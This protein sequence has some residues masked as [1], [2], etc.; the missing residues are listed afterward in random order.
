MLLLTGIV[1]QSACQSTRND[2]PKGPELRP[3]IRLLYYDTQGR[4]WLTHGM[5]EF[6]SWDGDSLVHYT[7]LPD[8]EKGDWIKAVKEDKEGNLFFDSDVGVIQRVGDEF[9]VLEVAGTYKPGEWTSG[10]DDLWFAG[11]KGHKGVFRYDGEDLY[12]MEFPDHPMAEEAAPEYGSYH[13]ELIRKDSKGGVW[14]GTQ[15]QGF[16]YFLDGQLYGLYDAELGVF[17]GTARSAWY[18]L[19]EDDEG[20][21]YINKA[22]S[23]IRVLE[24][25]HPGDSVLKSLA[26]KRLPGIEDER[27][28]DLHFLYSTAD[29]EGNLWF[30]DNGGR[31]WQYD[32]DRLN[33]LEVMYGGT[34]LYC[35]GLYT[36]RMGRLWVFMPQ[37]GMFTYEY[38]NFVKF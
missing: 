9:V 32:G 4:Y 8:Y 18:S 15:N 24:E 7:N 31:L 6:Y 20:Y 3:A 25:Q 17:P 21:I 29:A 28:T 27:I 37:S 2:L 26:Y 35:Y 19:V 38:G 1:C 33:Q 16:F 12:F 14:F 22:D 13:T 10:T 23:K 34:Y 11:G 36:D 5:D 30:G